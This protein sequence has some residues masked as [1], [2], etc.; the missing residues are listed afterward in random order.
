MQKTSSPTLILHARDD[1]T[2][3]HLY[4]S[5][6]FH[7]L[8]AAHIASR[9]AIAAI[10]VTDRH[11]MQEREG[12]ISSITYD[13]WGTVHSFN[14]PHSSSSSPSGHDGAPAQSEVV[15]WDGLKG[16]HNDIGWSEGSIDLIRRV[17]K[18]V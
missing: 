1:G 8:H 6:L 17:A 14:R 2:I 9:D 13:H 10:N 15:Y 11:K 4:S 16:G 3:P 12:V 18:L 7:S 5:K